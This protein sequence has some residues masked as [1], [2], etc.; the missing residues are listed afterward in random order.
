MN[1]RFLNALQLQRGKVEPHNP[2][3]AG[4]LGLTVNGQALVEVPDRPS[5]VYVQVRSSQ[6]E[7]IQAFNQTVSPVFN[8]PVFIQW[9]GNRYVVVERDTMRYSNWQDYSAYLPRHASTHEKIGSAGDVVFVSQDQFLPLLPQPSGSNA[10]PNIIIN[11]YSLMTTTGSF[12]YFPPTT[13]ANLTVWKPSSPTGSIMVLV[14]LDEQTSSLSY[15]VGSGS[16]FGNWLTGTNDILPF[17]PSVPDISRYL[18]LAAVRLTSTT[19]VLTW[20]NIYDLRPIYGATRAVSAGGGGGGSASGPGVMASGT[21]P[22]WL[23]NGVFVATGTQINLLGS[24]FILSHSGT[25]IQLNIQGG[26]GGAT[27][28]FLSLDTSNGPLYGP[29]VVYQKNPNVINQYFDYST[30]V[31]YLSGTTNPHFGAAGE[32]VNFSTGSFAYGVYIDDEGSGQGL[33]VGSLGKVDLGPLANFSHNIDL[34][35]KK[36]VNQ[37]VVQI[38]RWGGGTNPASYA[39]PALV[40]N[41]HQTNQTHGNS[42]EVDMNYIP[43]WFVMP[44]YTGSFFGYPFPVWAAYLYDTLFSLP[45]GT[46]VSIWNMN[47]QV[48]E[49]TVPDGMHFFEGIGSLEHTGSNTYTH[50]SMTGKLRLSNGTATARNKRITDSSRVFLTVQNGSG[51]VMGFPYVYS[52]SAGSGFTINSTNLSDNYEV[53]YL[54]IEPYINI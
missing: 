40:V 34:H 42:L 24:S 1:S 7:V 46:P 49:W 30:I 16:V 22:I 47:N 2:M 21:A 15:L 13:S 52:R 45:T 27:G 28:S 10:S 38:D 4:T 26:G 41:E 43:Y 5:Y 39:G 51:T 23:N 36:L 18:P 3:I 48:M 12:Q 44:S 6:A 53:A 9:Q 25:E 17:V 50:G 54:I 33:F 19:T 11:D 29:L 31:G 20:D 8:L 35:Y 37:P 14:M 32:F